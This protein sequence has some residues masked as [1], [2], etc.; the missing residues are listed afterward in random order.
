LEYLINQQQGQFGR[1]EEQLKK[2]SAQID[3]LR[4]KLLVDGK[5]PDYQENPA[6]KVRKI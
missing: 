5:R 4:Q 2:I 1:I 3:R 6:V